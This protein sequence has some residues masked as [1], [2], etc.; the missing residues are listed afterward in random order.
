MSKVKYRG[1]AFEHGDE[2]L[3]VPPLPAGSLRELADKLTEHDAVQLTSITD[4]IRK[5]DIVV[6]IAYVALQRNYSD[7]T[8][9]MVSDLVNGENYSAIIQAAIGVD[10]KS[11]KVRDPGELAPVASVS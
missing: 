2:F 10:R 9:E 11:Q 8:R 5:V 6:D 4:I 7:I 3:I 1:V